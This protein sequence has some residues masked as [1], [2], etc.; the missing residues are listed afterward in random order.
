MSEL[1]L[2]FV[3]LLILAGAAAIVYAGLRAPA[4]KPV[5]P[6]DETEPPP[7]QAAD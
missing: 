3:G 5:S 1:E 6:A 2:A 4:G 7:D